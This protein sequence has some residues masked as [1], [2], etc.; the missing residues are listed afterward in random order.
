MLNYFTVIINS[1]IRTCVFYIFRL[2]DEEIYDLK[3]LDNKLI[4]MAE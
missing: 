4:N 3:V 2:F 1:K